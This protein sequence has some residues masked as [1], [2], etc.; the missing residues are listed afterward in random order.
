MQGEMLQGT[1]DSLVLL[2]KAIGKGTTALRETAVED[3]LRDLLE[4]KD[5]TVP[6]DEMY[7]LKIEFLQE[8]FQH[9]KEL[10]GQLQMEVAEA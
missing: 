9:Q 8:D 1:L 4:K 7:R 6:E 10:L 2:V 3:L 5:G